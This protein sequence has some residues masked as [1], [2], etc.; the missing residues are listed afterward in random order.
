M[1]LKLLG[2]LVCMI[3]LITMPIASGLNYDITPECKIKDALAKT[4]I[5]GIVL[6]PKISQDGKTINFLAIRLHFRTIDV[7]GF[8]SGI[9]K[10]HYFQIPN[11]FNGFF[12]NFY[13]FGSFRGKL[14][15]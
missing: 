2:F 3:V 9:V 11:N 1:K 4:T 15:I 12:G 7:D 6:F 5:R 14:S 8:S 13:I 10:L